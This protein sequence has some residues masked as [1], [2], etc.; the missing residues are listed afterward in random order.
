MDIFHAPTASRLWEIQT[1]DYAELIPKQS[2]L[3]STIQNAF[4]VQWRSSCSHL[5]AHVVVQTCDL[6]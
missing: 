6:D 1:D 2:Q 3:K 4:L 5:Q